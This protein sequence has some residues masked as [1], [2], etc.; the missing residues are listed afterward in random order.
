MI[1]GLAV[2]SEFDKKK[3]IALIGAAL[4]GVGGASVAAAV[5]G[6]DA[7]FKRYERPDYS[8]YPGLYTIDRMGQALPRQE[9]SFIS[10]GVRLAGYLYSAIAPRGLIIVAHGFHA[11]ADD[12]LPL[13]EYMHSVGFTVFSYDVC[14]TYSSSGDSTVGMCQSLVDIDSAIDF[15]K[16]D[17][18][19]SSL[20]MYLIGHSWGGYAATAILSKQKGVRAAVGIAPMNNG[21]TMILEKGEQYAGKLAAEIPQPVISAYQKILF[22][23]Y[24]TYSGAR[25][26]NDSGIPVLCIQGVSDKVI[27][28]NGQSVSAKRGE[29][30]NPNFELL[31]VKG[32]LGGHDAIWHS[33][34]S[35]I[36]RSEI[37]DEIKLLGLNS[38][39]K[40]T[41]EERR[42]IISGV[43]HRLYS[44]VN[45][46]L[47]ERIV[48]FFLRA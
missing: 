18:S 4:A 3:K 8:L 40:A 2:L 31:T 10:R 35:Y 34:R 6:Y 36:Y 38:G 23:E 13:I 37:E 17:E 47:M 20:P 32:V 9:L 1:G 33:D 22:G 43:N 30:T 41:D 11:G 16:G 15:V 42:R 14:G 44:E 27:T 21:Y 12:Y 46:P 26:I 48:D 28:Y 29:I 5:V 45:F 39:R 7:M 25:G 24:T 19:L